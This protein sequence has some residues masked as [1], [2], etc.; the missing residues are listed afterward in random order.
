MREAKY[1][2]DNYEGVVKVK[3]HGEVLYNV[4]METHSQMSVNNLICETLHPNNIIAKLYTTKFKHSDDVRDKIILSLK[5]CV[6]NKDTKAYNS[7]VQHC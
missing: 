3:Y 1:F 5:K 2:L 7:I 6:K 4:L